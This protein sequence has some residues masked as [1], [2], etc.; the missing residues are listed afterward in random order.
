MHRCMLACAAVLA[1]GD[2]CGLSA[3]QLLALLP[4]T[5][6]GDAGA[7]PALAPLAPSGAGER[8]RPA[9]PEGSAGRALPTSPSRPGAPTAPGEPL[10]APPSRPQP[11]PH[12]GVPA[13]PLP[14]AS[15]AS[16]AGGPDCAPGLTAVGPEACP[17][18][19]L[20]PDADPCTDPALC[21]GGSALSAAGS[22]SE[23][24]RGAAA[25]AACAASAASRSPPS[26]MSCAP[27]GFHI[28]S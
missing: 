24:A 14:F 28:H 15:L 23:P 9:P 4:A 3:V 19:A 27:K 5:R 7:P 25:A 12:T 20:G 6:S 16:A 10:F 21:A 13:A 17:S 8:A 11:P 1:N 22:A 26:A 18:A 2:A